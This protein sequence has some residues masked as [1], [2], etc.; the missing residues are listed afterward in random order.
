MRA[1]HQKIGLFLGSMAFGLLLILPRTE[2]ARVGA[3]AA[4]MVVW[5]MTEAIPIKGDP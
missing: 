5:W 1:T 2:A 3:V 4:L